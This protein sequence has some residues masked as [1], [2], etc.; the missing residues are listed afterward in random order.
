MKRVKK[1]KKKVTAKKIEHNLSAKRLRR[2]AQN[3]GQEKTTKHKSASYI[4]KIRSRS[5]AFTDI[6]FDKLNPSQEKILAEVSQYLNEAE[7]YCVDRTMCQKQEEK[8]PCRLYVTQDFPRLAYMWGETL[9]EPEEKLPQHVTID[10]PEW[11][12]RKIMV[13]PEIGLSLLLGTDYLGEIKKAFL[14]LA[15]YKA[16][17]EGGLGLHAGSKVMRVYDINNQLVEK[18]AIFFGLSGTGKTTLTCHHHFLDGEESVSVRQD[19]VILLKPD[20]YCV[21]TEKNFYIKTEGLEPVSQPML[22]NAAVTEQAILE[23]ITVYDDG[24]VDFLEYSLTTNG[25]CIVR[26]AD[27]E[28]ADS[29]IDLPHLDIIVFIT[30]REDIVPSVAKL[31][32]EQAAAFFMLGESIETSAG[33]PK[34]AGQSKRV[35]GTNPFIVGLPDEE[36]N[37]FLDILRK[38]PQVE[39]FLLNTGKI[40]G[41]S[42]E[43]IKVIDSVE[44]VKQIARG[45]ISWQEDPD[46]HYQVAAKI[47]GIDMTRFD[48]F[49]FYTKVQYKKLTNVLKKE[50]KDWLSQ[51]PNLYPEITKAI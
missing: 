18:G 49:R 43:K 40:G 44:I 4:T 6:V 24:Q 45:G 47:E 17:K 22:Y 37:R 28:L 9:F 20:G 10:I 11:K 29:E 25:R 46:W 39:C 33:D 48:P 31:T 30:R 27:L 13:F 3:K 12:E 5:A 38:N 42:G 50:R 26:R 14:R 15:M 19:D 35:V 51:F 36:G 34:K 23:N 1:L 2:H 21:G 32:F 16:K 8:I 7:F 41:K